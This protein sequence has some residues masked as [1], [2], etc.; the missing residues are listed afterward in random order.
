M[1][2]NRCWIHDTRKSIHHNSLSVDQKLFEIPLDPSKPENPGFR[3]LQ[4][5]VKLMLIGPIY[6]DLFH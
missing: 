1:S 4:V 3:S 5:M 6:V 2:S